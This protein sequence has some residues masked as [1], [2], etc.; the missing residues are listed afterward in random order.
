MLFQLFQVIGGPNHMIM[1]YSLLSRCNHK[2]R[3]DGP[4]AFVL[5]SIQGLIV[6]V[7]SSL[8]DMMAFTEN[9][10]GHKRMRQARSNSSLHETCT[11]SDLMTSARSGKVDETNQKHFPLVILLSLISF[12]QL[13]GQL[14]CPTVWY[15]IPLLTTLTFRFRL[16]IRIKSY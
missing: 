7:R 6:E 5:P 12:W 13:L 4:M 3:L 11:I 10:S 15:L 2:A 14:T 1:E 9:S 8:R 16:R